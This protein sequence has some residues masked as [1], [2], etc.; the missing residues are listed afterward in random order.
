[1]DAD[2][3]WL[4]WQC[5]PVVCSIATSEACVFYYIEKP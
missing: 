3:I 1:M 4:S 2:D 5:Q